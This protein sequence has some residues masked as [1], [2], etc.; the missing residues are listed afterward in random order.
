MPSVFLSHSSED[1]D[2]VREIYYKLEE[3]NISC[4][5]DEAEM[6]PGDII[7]EKINQGLSKVD[8]IIVFLSRNSISSSWVKSEINAA[9]S[10][11]RQRDESNIVPVFLPNIDMN[12]IPPLLKGIV[13][14]KVK[15]DNYDNVI[16]EIMSSVL[17]YYEDFHKYSIDIKYPKFPANCRLEWSSEGIVEWMK[18]CFTGI[19]GSISPNDKEYKLVLQN[20]NYKSYNICQD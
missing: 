5:F 16:K 1:N 14:I 7:Y 4:W 11:G 17:R 10:M 13:G 3:K 19:V 18:N 20:I 8:F 15:N 2:I 12:D 9:F 6:K